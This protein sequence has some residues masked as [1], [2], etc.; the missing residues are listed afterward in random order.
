MNRFPRSLYLRDSNDIHRL[1]IHVAL[2]IGMK[3]SIELTCLIAAS[4]EHLKE[5]DPVTKWPPFVVAAMGDSC[6]LITIYRLLHDSP[7]HVEMRCN[8]IIK[9]NYIPLE[10]CKRKKMNK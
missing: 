1:P 7:E 9:H 4:K 8:G 2:E 5:M 3:L 10:N 6:D